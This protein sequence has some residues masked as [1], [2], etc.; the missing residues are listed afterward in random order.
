[1]IISTP[2]PPPSGRRQQ[3]RSGNIRP[4]P[5]FASA[6]TTVCCGWSSRAYV[7]KLAEA[8]HEILTSTPICAVRRHSDS[9]EVVSAGGE[10]RR[11][12][13]IVLATHADQALAMLADPRPE[14]ERLLG[15]LGY[16]ANSAML[17]SDATLMPHRRCVWSSWNYLS[18]E[19]GNSRR[20][21]VSYWMNRLQGLPNAKPMFLTLN[22][23][24]PVRED[25]I[26][27]AAE[28]SHPIFNARAMN[29]QRCL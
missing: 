8:I 5:S 12:D 24:R 11:F 13:Q 3:R 18:S 7:D 10:A 9:V 21:A 2:W 25:S 14:E 17:D 15:A 19:R 4:E 23:H 26:S 27:Y 22:A 16:C 6:R 20:L 1:L 29:A 28:Y